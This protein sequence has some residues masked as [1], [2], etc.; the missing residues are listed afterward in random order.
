[1]A[2]GDIGQ[3]D[4]SDSM[5]LVGGTPNIAARLQE[6]RGPE[7]GHDQRGNTQARRWSFFL[8]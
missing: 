1:M 5:D 4:P 2:T 6:T 3:G 8:R 7:L